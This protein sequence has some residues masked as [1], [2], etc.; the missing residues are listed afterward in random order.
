MSAE[1]LPV[2]TKK[3]IAESGIVGVTPLEMIAEITLEDRRK[4]VA[5]ILGRDSEDGR[6]WHVTSA[7]IDAEDEGAV[8]DRKRFPITNFNPLP[9]DTEYKILSRLDEAAQRETQ[10]AEQ[11]HMKILKKGE[12]IF[13]DNMGFTYTGYLIGLIDKDTMLFS[14]AAEIHDGQLVPSV[15]Y[16]LRSDALILEYG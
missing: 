9:R 5:Y 6:I 13:G 12:M 4:T 1:E 16:R 14:H 3:Q 2:Y 11:S 8:E 7:R 15:A 10:K